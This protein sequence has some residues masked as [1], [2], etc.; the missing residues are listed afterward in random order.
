MSTGKDSSFRNGFYHMKLSMDYFDDYVREFGNS[1]GSDYA[2]RYANKIRWCLQDFR[3]NTK[4]PQYAIEDMTTE[5]ENDVYAVDSI[6]RKSKQLN[7]EQKEVLDGLLD[8]LIAGEEIT[9]E[10]NKSH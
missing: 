2:K 8:M 7:T 10:L 6:A 9:V 3:T 1:V 4:F 5:L